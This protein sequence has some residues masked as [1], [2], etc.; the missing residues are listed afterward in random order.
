MSEESVARLYERIEYL[1]D[2]VE[3]LEHALEKLAEDYQKLQI[4]RAREHGYVAGVAALAAVVG[5][6]LAKFL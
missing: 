6:I 4:E 5:G 2:R 3:R 1:V